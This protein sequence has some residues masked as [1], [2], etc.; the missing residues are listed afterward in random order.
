M[1]TIK[2][3]PIYITT[4]G[5]FHAMINGVDPTD[6][7]FLIGTVETPDQLNIK[8]RWDSSGFCRDSDPKCNISP[9]NDEIKDV[10]E[11]AN[12]LMGKVPSLT[13]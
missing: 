1:A 8:V 9:N 12:I 6:G 11:T 7:D 4:V 5:G 2:I 3:D 10:I 13:H